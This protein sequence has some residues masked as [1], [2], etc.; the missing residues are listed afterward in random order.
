MAVAE[1]GIELVM[2]RMYPGAELGKHPRGDTGLAA[3]AGIHR[4]CDPGETACRPRHHARGEI[5]AKHAIDGM[6][7]ASATRSCRR[8]V[9]E[10]HTVLGSDAEDPDF[11]PEDKHGDMLDLAVATVDEEITEVFASLPEGDERF[12]PIAGRG[13][14]LGERLRAIHHLGNV[15]AAIRAHGDLH[16]G[17]ALLG[18]DGRWMLLDFEG[19][20]ARSLRERR[21][22][23]SPLRDVAALLGSI[24]YAAAASRLDGVAVP[25]GWETAAREAVLGAY[26]ERVDRALL[27]TGD[28]AT[29]TLLA[30]FELEKAVYELR[31]EMN[32]RLDW[33]VI[34]VARIARLIEAAPS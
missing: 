10:L 14:E 2:D 6:P 15:G 5:A 27:P 1:L 12:A 7:T 30:L 18:E 4:D 29:A 8:V 22:K 19:E 17:Q 11:A 24:S 13:A 25:E 31:Y 3:A 32:N 26:L 23:R 33:V 9:G 20:P 28:D 34:P 16:L 21:R